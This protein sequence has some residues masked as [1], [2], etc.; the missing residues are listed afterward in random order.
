[1][2]DRADRASTPPGP[3]LA[4]DDFK[5]LGA[6]RLA[7]RKFLAFSQAGSQAL[8]L[9]AQQ[10][11]ALLAVKA[12]EGPYAMSIGELAESLLIKNHS[13]VGLVER[14]VKRGLLLRDA[15]AEDRRRVLLWLTPESETILETISRNNLHQL[16][17]STQALA[18]LLAALS[19]LEERSVSAI[20]PPPPRSETS[21][22]RPKRSHQ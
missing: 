18:D 8:G 1:M 16:K 2:P 10:H 3:P 12:H 20:P 5:A 13:A 22:R 14:L 15:A 21:G 11:Q 9:T 6:F 19:R 7:L 17:G 4:D